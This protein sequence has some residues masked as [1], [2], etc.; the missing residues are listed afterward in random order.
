MMLAP[1]LG[2]MLYA[3]STIFPNLAMYSCIGNSNCFSCVNLYLAI[4]ALPYSENLSWS[5]AFIGNQLIP[6]DT[7]SLIYLCKVPLKIARVT[8][9]GFLSQIVANLETSSSHMP[10]SLGFLPSHD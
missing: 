1:S 3:C 7:N 9:I 6:L 8:S 4:V 5:C 10:K 2:L